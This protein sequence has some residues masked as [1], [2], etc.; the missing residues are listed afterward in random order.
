MPIK[1][2]KPIFQ[3]KEGS[4]RVAI[5]KNKN[6]NGK[7]YPY[8]CVTAIRFPFKYCSK[9][10]LKAGEIP[11]LITLLQ[12]MPDIEKKEN[13]KGDIKIKEVKGESLE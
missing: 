8:I 1:P 4:M 12:R 5:F 7:I 9:I 6:A 2:T 13:K 3:D 10:H 11:K